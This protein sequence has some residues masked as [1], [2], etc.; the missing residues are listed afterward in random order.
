MASPQLILRQLVGRLTNQPKHA[1][2]IKS[3]LPKHWL[4]IHGDRVI[5][6]I[7]H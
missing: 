7:F 5:I 4:L 3:L 1:N 2:E 6:L